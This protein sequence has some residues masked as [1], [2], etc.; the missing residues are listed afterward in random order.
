MSLNSCALC[1][2]KFASCASDQERK[3][4]KWPTLDFWLAKRIL[5]AFIIAPCVRAAGSSPHS[6]ASAGW[7]S[8]TDR[9]LDVVAPGLFVDKLPER[10]L[11]MVECFDH[12]YDQP[13]F[14]KGPTADPV[15]HPLDGP[16]EYAGSQKR[17]MRSRRSSRSCSRAQV[18]GRYDGVWHERQE[19]RHQ[20]FAGSAH[21]LSPDKDLPKKLVQK[22]STMSEFALCRTNQT[23]L[24]LD[25]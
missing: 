14:A 12:A 24:E 9:Q 11:G 23:A 7:S 3:S 17:R 20:E 4:R 1:A 10:G 19:K 25:Q 21:E 18:Y 8:Q 16:E 5:S 22:P 15:A 13:Q 6:S 2:S